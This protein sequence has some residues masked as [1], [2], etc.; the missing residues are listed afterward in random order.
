M[1]I[2]KEYFYKK[3]PKISDGVIEYLMLNE[4][5]ISSYN[6]KLLEKKLINYFNTRINIIANKPIFTWKSYT[7]VIG[8]NNYDKIDEKWLETTLNFFGYFISKKY[9]SN[10]I[11]TQLTIEPNFPII[12]NTKIK[13]NN[14]SYL[15]HITQ[16]KHLNSINK[17]GLAPSGTQTTYYHPNDRIYLLFTHNYNHIKAFKT[18]LAR[19]KNIPVDDLIVFK[20]AFDDNYSYY[21]DDS[22][23]ILDVNLFSCF[24]LKNISPN[25]LEL[26]TL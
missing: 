23:T 26:T 6:I 18:T 20:T 19:D 11:L 9:K 13:E 14:I 21:L 10:N 8:I 2:L 22:A 3:Q 5:L 12:I 4:S 25:K 17:I 1:N 7:I 15:Y 24:I 16:L